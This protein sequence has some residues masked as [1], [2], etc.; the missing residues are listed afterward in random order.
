MRFAICVA[1]TKCISVVG[2]YRISVPREH[3]VL[4]SHVQWCTRQVTVARTSTAPMS[5]RDVHRET[6][7]C[8]RDS[9]L[10]A[11][12]GGEANNTV[13]KLPLDLSKP[14]THAHAH[15][16]KGDIET[17]ASQTQGQVDPH[18][19]HSSWRPASGR[20][21]LS[22]PT[23]KA[24]ESSRAAPRPVRNR[25]H[26]PMPPFRAARYGSRLHRGPFWTVAA[27]RR[28]LDRLTCAL[29]CVL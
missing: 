23:L 28:G 25:A 22:H 17:N 24:P 7:V 26:S 8:N 19:H 12:V 5:P 20:C 21:P 16:G 15:R 29:F 10:H 1:G 18:A 2:V 13:S 3:E 11:A 14:T 6:A 9:H 4:T 27:V